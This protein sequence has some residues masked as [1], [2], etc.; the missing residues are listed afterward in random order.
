[1]N[2]SAI[3]RY[4]DMSAPASI[5]GRMVKFSKDGK[6]VTSDDGAAI[7]ED[8]D[9]IALTDETLVGWLRFNDDAPP[10]RVMG[11]LSVALSCR[12]ARASAIPMRRNGR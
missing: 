7:S 10:D 8:E 9:F 4:L 1:M 6:F 3:N 12:R 11:L 5:V 2:R